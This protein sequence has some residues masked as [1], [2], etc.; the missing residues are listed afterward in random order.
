MITT[1]TVNL[2]RYLQQFFACFAGKK[3]AAQC[4][5]HEACR[6]ITPVICQRRPPPGKKETP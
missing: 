2:L 5:P 1:V 3:T 4:L 6:T